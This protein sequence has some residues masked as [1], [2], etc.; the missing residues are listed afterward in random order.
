M[1]APCAKRS[2][3]SASA[4]KMAHQKASYRIRVYYCDDCRSFHVTNADKRWSGTW[5]DED[6]RNYANMFKPPR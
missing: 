3:A 4:A 5:D 1:A 6:K 2:Y